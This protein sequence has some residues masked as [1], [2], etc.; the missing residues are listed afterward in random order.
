MEP[1]LGSA[2]VEPDKDFAIVLELADD[3]L[4]TAEAVVV[5]LTLCALVLLL[6]TVV[7]AASAVGVVVLVARVALRWLL[8]GVASL[9]VAAAV[10][11]GKDE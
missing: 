6:C 10:P 4:V 8:S 2:V 11:A 1:D 7:V 5:V 3:G 9:A